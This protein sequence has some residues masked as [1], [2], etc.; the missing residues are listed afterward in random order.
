MIKLTLIMLTLC[1]G[2]ACSSSKEF[3]A[4]P[5]AA[6][7]RVIDP[8]QT[9][10]LK[11]KNEQAKEKEQEKVAKE[12]PAIIPDEE[13]V[14]PTPEPLPVPVPQP[15]NAVKKGSFVAW[16]IP[17]NPLPFDL[18]VIHIEISYPKINELNRSDISGN[19][20][21]TD[22]Y[23]QNIGFTISDVRWDKVG[24]KAILEIAVPGGEELVSDTINIKSKALNES[25]T[26]NIIFQ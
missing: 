23:S 2:L 20:I 13:D 3:K 14:T 9:E 8:K 25:Q 16:T 10:D 18:Y 4:T 17:S 1:S 22:Y 24:D 5:K 26:L 19:I 15:D 12:E 21:G 6:A 11:K 7:S